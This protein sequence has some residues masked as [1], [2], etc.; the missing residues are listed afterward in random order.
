MTMPETAPP[1]PE[2]RPRL[3]TLFQRLDEILGQLD[4]EDVDLEEQMA[5]Y[6]EA[7]G[8]LAS[9]RGILDETHAEIEF[10]MGG[11]AGTPPTAE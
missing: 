2:G 3:S 7:C 10:L 6:R 11:D 9:A 8:H 5:L 1:P 4:R